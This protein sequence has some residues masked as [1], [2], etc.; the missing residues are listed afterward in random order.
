LSIRYIARRTDEYDGLVRFADWDFTEARF[1]VTGRIVARCITH[2]TATGRIS[3]LP[4]TRPRVHRIAL[5]TT[6]RVVC[7]SRRTIIN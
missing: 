3:G 1:A 5:G 2:L 4:A 7:E 6:P